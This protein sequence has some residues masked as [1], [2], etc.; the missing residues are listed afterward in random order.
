RHM[1]SGERL[2]RQPAGLS[3]PFDERV[4][5]HPVEKVLSALPDGEDHVWVALVDWAQHLIGNEAGHLVHQSRA[6]TKS[7][8]ESGGILRLDVDTIGNSDHAK[9]P[10]IL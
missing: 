8:L 7:L 3:V 2:L 9:S 1:R 6:L 10:F 4:G 5:A